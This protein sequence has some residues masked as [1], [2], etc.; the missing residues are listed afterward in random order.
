MDY[1]RL[2][3]IG[4]IVLSLETSIGDGTTPLLDRH[5][6]KTNNFDGDSS[7]NSVYSFDDL[8]VSKFSLS[9]KA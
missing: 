1:T 3:L 8:K 4:L 6:V 2:T 9:N 5:K 7:Y